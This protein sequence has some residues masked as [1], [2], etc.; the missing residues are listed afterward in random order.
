[1]AVDREQVVKVGMSD[2][3]VPADCTGLSGNY[4]K[5]RDAC[6]SREVRL[7]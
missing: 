2:Y 4:D 6:G 3:T 7:D 1:M 5:W